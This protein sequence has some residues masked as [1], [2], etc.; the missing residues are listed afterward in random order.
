MTVSR[1]KLRFSTSR[2]LRGWDDVPPKICAYPPG[3]STSTAVRWRTNR[4][5]WFTLHH[6]TVAYATTHAN[7]GQIGWFNSELPSVFF[8]STYFTPGCC[9]RPPPTTSPLLAHFVDLEMPLGLKSRVFKILSMVDS[10][11]NFVYKCYTIFRIITLNV[12]YTTL[13]NLTIPVVYD[14]VCCP[15]KCYTR[16]VPLSWRLYTLLRFYFTI[17]PLYFNSF[18]S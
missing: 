15:E 7:I 10:Q 3:W 9:R 2:E 12:L 11:R 14:C 5:P 8:S 6:A 16:T 4:P 18:Q 17:M 13:W 1:V